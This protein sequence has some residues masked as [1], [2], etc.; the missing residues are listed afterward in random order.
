MPARI[1]VL[2]GLLTVLAVLLGR[3]PAAGAASASLPCERP[4]WYPTSF[5]LKDHDVFWYDGYYYIIANDVPGEDRFAYGRSKDLCAWEELS[6][7]LPQRT[8]GAADERAVWAPNV[9]QEGDTFY[10][11]YTGVTLEFTQRILLAETKTPSDPASWQ[12]KGTVFQ[13]DHPGM[14]WQDKTFAD[15]RDPSVLKADG[16]YYLY[17]TGRDTSGG[18]LGLSSATSPDG[19]WK[20]WGAVVS[21][22]AEAG[23]LE[24]STILR[25][26]GLYYLFYHQTDR[27]ERYRIGPSPAGPWSPTYSLGPGWAHKIWQGQD[28]ITYTSYLTTNV[29]NIAHLNWDTFYSPPRPFIGDQLYR[30]NLPFIIQ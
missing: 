27:G 21:V 14:L 28:Q 29:I 24:S 1:T 25:Y 12:P 10:L 23:M 22:P 2:A 26:E 17:Y 15:S 7:V 19:P 11:Y 4:G 13:P 18:I 3:Q 16:L 20:D 8:P 9:L 6:P 30:L 5:G